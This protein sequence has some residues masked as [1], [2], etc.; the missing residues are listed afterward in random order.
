V[1]FNENSQSELAARMDQDL[2]EIKGSS[3]RQAWSAK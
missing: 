2:C 1:E 3:R